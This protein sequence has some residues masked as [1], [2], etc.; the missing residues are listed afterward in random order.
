MPTSYVRNNAYHKLIPAQ[1]LSF[2]AGAVACR[3]VRRKRE[4]HGS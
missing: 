1:F 2:V 3:K 4:Q